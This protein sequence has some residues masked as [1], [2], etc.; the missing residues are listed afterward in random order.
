MSQ[1]NR[2]CTR[3]VEFE[4][5]PAPEGE[6]SDGRTLEGYG[7][8][9]DTPTRI[10]NWEGD[11]EERISPGAFT[12]T[13]SERKPIMQYDHGRDARTGSVPIGAIQELREDPKGLYVSARL[14]DNPIVE[15]IRQ[16]IEGGAISGMSFKFNVKRDEWRDGRGTLLRPE[17]LGRLLHSSGDRGPLQRNIKEVQLFEVGPVA[18]PA[19]AGTSVGV[20]SLTD[21]E[22]E[23][24]VDEY[25]KTMHVE[26]EAPGFEATT[27][28]LDGDGNLI[29]KQGDEEVVIVEAETRDLPMGSKE[30]CQHSW[31]KLHHDEATK[32][33]MTPDERKAA[34]S[35]LLAAA[36]KFD[37]KLHK[38]PLPASWKKFNDGKFV[39]SYEDMDEELREEFARAMAETDTET[40]ETETPDAV[41]EDTSAKATDTDDAARTGTSSKRETE[42]TPRKAV[43]M[44][45]TIDELRARLDEISVRMQEIGSDETR[46]L[47]D[48]EQTEFDALDTE[49]TD[50]ERSIELIEKR[51]ERIKTLASRGA[52][53]G[54]ADT[55]APAFHRDKNQEID[56][57]DIRKMSY[58]GD[59][60]LG[61]VDDGAR[62]V[63]ERSTYGV[64]NKEEAQERAEE[65]LD[66]VDNAD[67]LLAKR[68]LITGGKDYTSG[69]A[70]LLRHGTDAFCTQDERQALQRAQTLGTDS[71][72]GFAVPFQLDPTV[73][74][75][76]A[77]VKNPIRDLAR[78]ETI[79]GKEWN[80]V[81][82]TGTSVTRAGENAV[83][84]AS[85]FTLAQP[86]VR[87]NRVQGYSTFSIEIDL[88]WG[89][90]Q[91]EITRL[92]VDAKGQEEN[93]FIS[94]AGDGFTDGT[95]PQ[96][97]NAGLA[98]GG[99]DV[100][101]AAIDL[102]T[103]ADL[104]TLE[105]ALDARWEANASFLAHKTVYNKIR[106]FPTDGSA[107][108][109]NNLWTDLNAGLSESTRNT[110]RL[111]DYPTYRSAGPNGMPTLAAAAAYA[112]TTGDGGDTLMI[113]GD[114]SQF[115]I[116]DRIGMSVE[117]VPTVLDT[118]THRPIGQRGVYTYWMNNSKILVPGAFK[119]LL[120]KQT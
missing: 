29:A 12:K 80:G 50:I 118:A 103:L 34:K 73:I 42:N 53:E 97:I 111:L 76:S 43:P 67:R 57:D 109:M 58:S 52:R 14:F 81:T 101:A 79:V 93:S 19:Y 105:Q 86:K 74:L 51:S 15:P 77:G 64:R 88:S 100:T 65:L 75:T 33:S 82:T 23:A 120:N 99:N 116:V 106:Q 39:K 37:I 4:S 98:G 55:G 94:G 36:V 5:T 102:F 85:A 13:L 24:L 112:G 38:D 10:N 91:S 87:T 2:L 90:L 18:S 25:R 72:G 8:V 63:I 26:E 21:E 78:V 48:T 47:E 54:G 49:S 96:G 59:D 22:R 41:R 40:S 30:E 62:R 107:G 3:S 66:T 92:L 84:P 68:M 11:F 32:K 17:E 104:F 89:A 60:F 117:V 27:V 20:R 71:G 6:Q 44:A 70:K 110:R 45:K 108:S 31:V 115:M 7:A 28:R 113:L 1:I 9:F 16:A 35:K 114:F 119:R 69:F 46:S 95:A 83:A 61:R 56:L